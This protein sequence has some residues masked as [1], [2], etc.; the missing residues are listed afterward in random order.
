MANNTFTNSSGGSWSSS[1]NWS[2][3]AT[4]GSSDQ[5]S[6]VSGTYTSLVD[7]G[8][9]TITSLNVNVTSV[10]LEVSASLTVTGSTS[11]S[12]D[13]V[14][15]NG[16]VL[17]LGSLAVNTGTITVNGTLDV[18]DNLLART[19]R[20]VIIASGLVDLD[21]T[22]NG[23]FSV[24]GG[25][26]EI[27]GSYIGNDTVELADGV[28]WLAGSLG[29]ATFTLDTASTDETY[30]DSL[31]SS[32]SNSFSGGSIGDQIGIKGVTITSDSYSG[33]TLTLNTTG[34]SFTFTNFALASG[35]TLG[36][37]GTTTFNGNSYGYV[38]LACFATGTL[39][40]TP[41]GPLPVEALQQSTLLLTANGAV[42][43]IRWVGWR[44]LDFRRHPRPA[45]AQPIRI[46]SGAFGDLVPR[47]DLLISPDH[48]IL[49]DGVLI[50]IRL[51]MNG[52]TISREDT[53]QSVTYYH[54]ELATHDVILAEGLAAESYLDTGNRSIFE[55]AGLP[56]T[57]HPDLNA[58]HGQRRRETESCR[59]L[60]TDPARVH[61]IWQRLADRSRDLGYSLPEVPAT[62][63]AAVCLELDG[64]RIK[65]TIMR[66]G[67]CAFVLR[68]TGS[69]ARLLSHATA[70]CELA[71]WVDDQRELGI[72]VRRITLRS[73]EDLITIPLD[74]PDLVNGWWAY[75]RDEC[76]AWRWTNGAAE[77]MLP[78][79][80]PAVLEIEFGQQERYRDAARNTGDGTPG[81]AAYGNTLAA[82]A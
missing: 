76:S 12:G 55:N 32:T 42:R 52:A 16:A 69:S 21:G 34:G 27:G 17:N 9:W 81:D 3:A 19:G 10:T 2:L 38:Q 56:L 73:D 71:P 14:V 58:A 61:P 66:N 47:R 41:D 35:V 82:V 60:L 51:L 62:D 68:E 11:N 74:H 45:A 46:R 31:T 39:L 79:G 57:L 37:T 49:I 36:A 8:P 72:M 43:P 54:V 5:V 26:L 70:P 48:A 29:N 33:T 24:T 40:D 15:D 63:E 6:F 7:G 78:P 30:F 59:E 20:G 75:E 1:T 25:T 50:P 77:L 28:L 53:C 80:G 65:P 22:G 23:D 64:R 13:I 67:F 44:L 4:P 18:A